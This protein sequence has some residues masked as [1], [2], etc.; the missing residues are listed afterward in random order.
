MTR[1]VKM[2]ILVVSEVTSDMGLK[3]TQYGSL[4]A[5]KNHSEHSKILF[6]AYLY[7]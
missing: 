1:R 2:F 6:N 5:E 7:H 3:T 4:A